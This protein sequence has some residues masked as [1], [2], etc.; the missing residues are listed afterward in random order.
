M[1]DG[2][3]GMK[4]LRGYIGL[5][6]WICHWTQHNTHTLLHVLFTF[7]VP[8]N[9]ILVCLV[10]CY[11]SRANTASHAVSNSPLHSAM[12][13]PYTIVCCACVFMYSFVIRFDDLIQLTTIHTIWCLRSLGVVVLVYVCRHEYSYI[14]VSTQTLCIHMCPSILL[15]T[16]T[17]TQALTVCLFVK[18]R[19]SHNAAVDDVILSGIFSV[20]CAL[21]TFWIRADSFRHL[22][23]ARFARRAF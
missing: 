19:C 13:L 15:S 2:T 20:S 8:F 9:L 11:S 3:S 22:I 12:F 7:G 14:H 5:W 23:D 1:K 17:H 10:H 16:Q 21:V 4:F 6:I 18:R